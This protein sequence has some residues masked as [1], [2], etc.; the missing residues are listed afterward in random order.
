MSGLKQ[1]D[2]F[3]EGVTFQYVAPSGDTDLTVCGMPGPYDASKEFKDK[4]VVLVAVPGAFTPTCQVSHVTSYIKNLDKLKAAGVDQV[5]FIASNDA[6]VMAAWGK[7]NGIKDD[8]ILFMSDAE[9]A[10]SKSIG[11]VNGDRTKR[12][13]IIV[14]HGKVVYADVDDKRGSIENSGAEAVLAKL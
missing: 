4:K 3:P 11:W 2:A 1:G 9:T 8:S 14:D 6:W 5:I 12:Y 7:A 10:F 13:A